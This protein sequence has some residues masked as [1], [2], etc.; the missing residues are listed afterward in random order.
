L[1]ERL[2]NNPADA[3]YGAFQQQL[4]QAAPELCKL[5]WPHKYFF[6]LFPTKLDDYH[7]ERWHRFHLIKVLQKTSGAGG[8]VCLRGTLRAARR[9]SRL[10]D[11]TP[12]LRIERA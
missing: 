8:L 12:H 10:A 5:G 2:P 7:D 9:A 4:G 3:D 6:L 1:L 11:P